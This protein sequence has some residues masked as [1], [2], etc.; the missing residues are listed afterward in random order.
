M[1]EFIEFQGLLEADK[2]LIGSG[3]LNPGKI[4]LLQGWK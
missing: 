1:Y 4:Y 3:S 2:T